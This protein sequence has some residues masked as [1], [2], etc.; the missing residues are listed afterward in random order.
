[1]GLFSKKKN[2]PSTPTREDKLNEN[3]KQ[4][5]TTEITDDVANAK[6]AYNYEK[7]KCKIIG[8]TEGLKVGAV[9]YTRKQGILANV[10]SESVAQIENKKL[11]KMVD[12]FFDKDRFCT[13]KARFV[14]IEGNDLYCNLGFYIDP[15]PDDQEDD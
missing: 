12:D 7:V 10:A 11:Q 15:D 8:N 1:M 14:S 9:L 3:A 4:P 5:F 6:L 13:L 2:Q